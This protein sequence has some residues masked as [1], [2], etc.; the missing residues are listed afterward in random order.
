M[1]TST[2]AI[3]KLDR[4][5]LIELQSLLSRAGYQIPVDGLYGPQ[6]AGAWAQFK[7][8]NW[9]SSAGLISA[10]SYNQIK[11]IANKSNRSEDS[12]EDT[13]K[14]IDYKSLDWT[15]FNQKISKYFTVGEAL[16][17]DA[18]RIPSDENVKKNIVILATELDKMRDL[19]AEVVIKTFYLHV[20]DPEELEELKKVQGGIRI[21]SWYRPIAINRAVGGA[22]RSQH[23][24]GSAVDVAPV[25]GSLSQFQAFLDRN[26][27]GALGY[28]AQKGFVH[29][30]LRGYWDDQRKPDPRWNY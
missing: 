15:N 18:R 2:T 3:A 5:Q 25:K 27:Q 17:Y 21:A 13:S 30:D 8:D 9:L 12:S 10:T 7:K 11:A 1:I 23:L 4:E 19:W 29:L 16:R 24:L 28:G 14:A 20:K 26:W 6:T 22:R